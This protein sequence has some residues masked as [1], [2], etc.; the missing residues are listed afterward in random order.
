VSIQLLPHHSQKALEPPKYTAL[1]QD[2][3]YLIVIKEMT[4]HSP[5]FAVAAIFGARLC[6]TA[7]V[8]HFT[9]FCSSN[10]VERRAFAGWL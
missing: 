9:D 4:S 8:V 7:K 3:Q 10:L 1:V 5:Y 6:S 2:C